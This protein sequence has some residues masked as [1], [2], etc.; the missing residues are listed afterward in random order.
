MEITIR[1]TSTGQEPSVKS[2]LREKTRRLGE[3]KFPRS[4][5]ARQEFA[6][7]VLEDLATGR[8]TQE[9]SAPDD[10]GCQERS[11]QTLIP[12]ERLL[13]VNTC[14]TKESEPDL[15]QSCGL[16]WRRGRRKTPNVMHNCVPLDTED[17]ATVVLPL[18]G[19]FCQLLDRLES[20]LSETWTRASPNAPAQP[21]TRDSAT[22]PFSRH[23]KDLMKSY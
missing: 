3:R 12:T 7:L 6:Q 10:S 2:N 20:S 16:S 23:H 1:E 21:V 11:S 17:P 14:Q 8:T 22:M 5:S 18:G 19:N 4:P 13:D 15:P 9:T